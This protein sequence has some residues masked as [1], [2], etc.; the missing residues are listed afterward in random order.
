MQLMR[1]TFIKLSGSTAA[2]IYMQ[3]VTGGLVRVAQAQ[4]PGV[5][6]MRTAR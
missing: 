3:G 1:R 4:I 6:P 5:M 2:V